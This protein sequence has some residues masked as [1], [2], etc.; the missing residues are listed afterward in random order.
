MKEGRRSHRFDG[1][2]YFKSK[3]G[4]SGYIYIIS[5][6]TTVVSKHAENLKIFSMLC[7]FYIPLSSP[8]IATHYGHQHNPSNKIS[9]SPNTTK[10]GFELNVKKVKLAPLDGSEGFYLK[11]GFHPDVSGNPNRMAVVNNQLQSKNGKLNPE[12]IQRF[13][14]SS[15]IHQDFRG[16]S[17]SGSIQNIYPML[18]RQI[19]S[20]WEIQENTPFRIPINT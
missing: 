10:F 17:W 11:M 6:R 14:Q 1:L 7:Y 20:N 5:G 15:F 12:W 3:G 4:M 8:L 13:A 19:L 9:A 18:K 16:P 2:D